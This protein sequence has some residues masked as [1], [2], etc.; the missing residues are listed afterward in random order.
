MENINNIEISMNTYE[1]IESIIDSIT[2]EENLIEIHKSLIGKSCKDK[3]RDIEDC[4]VE[5]IKYLFSRDWG[6][7]IVYQY[8]KGAKK[9]IYSKYLSDYFKSSIKELL[10]GERLTP[11]I[12]NIL[13]SDKL[14]NDMSEEEINTLYFAIKA[15][16]NNPM[17]E[18]KVNIS[19]Q[20][21]ALLYKLDGKGVNLFIKNNVRNS[22][23]VRPILLTSGMSDRA[24]YYSGRG[25]NY[26][27]LSYKNLVAIFEKLFKL[28]VNY[29]IEFVEMVRQMKTLG[30]SEF[31]DSFRNFASNGFKMDT[32]KIENSNI[33]FDGCYG[34]TRDDL[35]LV[36]IYTAM[37]GGKDREYQIIASNEMK[38]S[39]IEI[40][41]AKVKQINPNFDDSYIENS[42]YPVYSR[43]K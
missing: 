35:A 26:G 9:F 20:F 21:M 39:F 16:Y 34:K 18:K 36:S 17:H 11:E 14:I 13:D 31:I 29:G 19:S 37:S 32:S 28:D 10:E 27:D 6:R 30:A 38:N 23:L 8:S 25:V 24:S 40:V 2:S 42:E 43:R 4:G 41:G 12:I 33:S 1:K 15:F 3:Y 7:S 22:D 5:F